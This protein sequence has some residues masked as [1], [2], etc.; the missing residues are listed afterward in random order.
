M[1][2]NHRNLEFGLDTFGD[3]AFDDTTKERISYSESLRNIVAEGK[4]ADEVGI[5]VIALGE[6]HREEYSISS[7]DTVLAALAMV[8][9]TIKLGTGVTVLSSD[10]PVRVYERS[11]TNHAGTRIFY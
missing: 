1:T 10:D 5:D 9:N 2:I 4:L 7:P 6:H 11:C 8:T 3:L